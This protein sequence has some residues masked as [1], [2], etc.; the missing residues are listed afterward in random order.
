MSIELHI[1]LE[2]SKVPTRDL[3]QAE[4]ERLGFP[5]VIDSPFDLQRD[6]GFRPASYEGAA[7]GFEFYLESSKT[8]IESYPHVAPHVGNRD[9]CATF[10]WGGDLAEMGAASAAAASLAK[11]TDGIYFH[12]DDDLLYTADEALKA[13]RTD[14][15][16]I[17]SKE[18]KQTPIV[19]MQ[20]KITR[21]WAEAFPGLGI[22]QTRQLLRRVGPIVAGIVLDR[23]SDGIGYW[24]AFHIHVL[25]KEFPVIALTLRAP[26]RGRRGMPEEIS[27]R[28]HDSKFPEAAER[29][30]AACLLPMQ[31][32]VH[33][34]D[35]FEAYEKWLRA[36]TPF[37]PNVFEE[38]ILLRAWAGQKHAVEDLLVQARTQL[39]KLPSA[40]LERQGGVDA[41]L[42]QMREATADRNRLEAILAS[43]IVAHKLAKLPTV[44]LLI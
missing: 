10:R 43:E 7:T 17:R 12:P 35:V 33:L 41:W 44:P 32:D 36:N 27:V 28:S 34:E 39:R 11:L 21:D 16:E 20:K 13:T 42:E 15:D 40:S 24:P 30:R 5:A 29:M 2:K 26:L 38:K 22:Y 19:A 8:I 31:G 4:I 6:T 9:V 25:L 1:F 18:P 14:L 37:W 3:W 23:K